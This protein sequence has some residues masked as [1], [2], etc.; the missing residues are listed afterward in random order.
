M[1]A[2]NG[3]PAG[4]VA[5]LMLDADA[6][7]AAAVGAAVGGAFNGGNYKATGTAA[8]AAGGYQQ[9]PVTL[10]AEPADPNGLTPYGALGPPAPGTD[11]YRAIDARWQHDLLNEDVPLPSNV[12]VND[13]VWEEAKAE[14]ASKLGITGGHRG[15]DARWSEKAVKRGLT[16]D[17]SATGFTVAEHVET[18]YRAKAAWY[19][20]RQVSIVGAWGRG[21]HAVDPT[22]M[23]DPSGTIH[24]GGEGGRSEYQRPHNEALGLYAAGQ[25][26]WA[27]TAP[28]LRRGS[29]G[30]PLLRPLYERGTREPTAFQYGLAGFGMAGAI[31]RGGSVWM[32]TA[33][34]ANPVPVPLFWHGSA[35]AVAQRE[36][37]GLFALPV[38]NGKMYWATA[39]DD[40]KQLGFDAWKIGGNTNVQ[41]LPPKL[42]NKGGI[43][44]MYKLTTAESA[45]F[46]RA[47][48]VDFNWNAFQWW[49]GAAKQYYYRPSPATWTQRAGELGKAIAIGGTAGGLS[50]AASEALAGQQQ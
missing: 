48:G 10:M 17:Y 12:R 42:V 41:L 50:W 5:Q 3:G 22:P 25:R 20:D 28:L 1:L 37:A 21:I 18:V 39:I 29:T 36:A 24:L 16:G 33:D 40:V 38:G 7:A 45:R 14:V 32:A 46:K 2:K 27:E 49:K 30:E 11:A 13:Q 6:A 34:A 31:A 26:T 19:R 15:V 8:R 9:Q 43:E 23:V 35:K 47:W 4:K 44:A